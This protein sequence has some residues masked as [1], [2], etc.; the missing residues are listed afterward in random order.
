[1][2]DPPVAAFLDYAISSK[3]NDPVQV[4]T[5]ADFTIVAS[6]G[7]TAPVYVQSISFEL[8]VGTIAKSLTP[9]LTGVGPGGPD[10][11]TTSISGNTFLAT[12]PVS[13]PPLPAGAL[14]GKPGLTFALTGVTIAAAVG[15]AKI[16]VK[17]IASTNSAPVQTGFAP[18][19][20]VS[21]FPAG[22]TLGPLTATPNLPSAG[23]KAT[24]T[25]LGSPANYELEYDPGSGA[26]T[27]PGLS[28]NVSMETVALDFAGPVD[29]Y[30]TVT[31]ETEGTDN[32]VV[33]QRKTSV[34]VT[35][36]APSITS[37]SGTVNENGEVSLQWATANAAYCTVSGFPDQFKPSASILPFAP[38]LPAYTLTTYYANGTAGTTSTVSC[39][40]GE[41]IAIPVAQEP[42]RVVLS[43]DASRAYVTHG[44]AMLGMG[45]AAG[46]VTVID[47]ETLTVLKNVSV[48]PAPYGVSA[49]DEALYVACSDGTIWELNARRLTTS[50]VFSGLS[51][52]MGLTVDGARAYVSNDDGTLWILDTTP[53]WIKRASIQLTSPAFDIVVIPP[54]GGRPGYV[55]AVGANGDPDN[56][57]AVSVITRDGDSYTTLP[58]VPVA[59]GVLCA[60]P[61]LDGSTLAVTSTAFGQTG[62][63]VSVID[64]TLSPPAL[65]FASATSGFITGVT[66]P[67]NS[68]VYFSALS[69]G[70]VVSSEVGVLDVATR[71]VSTIPIQNGIEASGIGASANLQGLFVALADQ[72]APS[73]DIYQVVSLTGGV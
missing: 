8:P 34:T 38:T 63:T 57:G 49:T 71:V 21:K 5:T 28:N 31:Y 51:Q 56:P 55:C 4:G 61:S 32:H 67:S 42:Y 27:L 16:T 59:P 73:V 54:T 58:S 9:S 69:L 48:G 1:M 43:P 20:I 37:Y 52:P 29:F 39:V 72:S 14:V 2:T 40:L 15:T 6:N 64:M 35:A 10:G 70:S 12:A 13:K 7:G 68:L 53:T 62:A 30:L 11:W 45:G 24:L 22:F 46:S 47:T 26:V 33:V 19:L 17:E 3:P 65:S 41:G 23:T 66:F 18:P 44:R 25:W 60:A 50:V 36:L